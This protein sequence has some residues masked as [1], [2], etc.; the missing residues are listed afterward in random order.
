MNA[1]PDMLNF[2]VGPVMSDDDILAIGAEQVP[3]FRTAEFSEVMKENEKMLLEL[4][5][6]PADSRAVFLTTSGTGAMEAA[7][8]NTL[9]TTDKVL[10][11]NGG[12]FGQRFCDLCSLH[13]IEHTAI[14]LKFGTPLRHEDLEPYENAGYTAFLVNMNETSSGVLYDIELISQFCKRNNL[15]LIVDAVSAFLTDPFSL[16]ASGAGIMLT[17]SQKALGCPPG[18]SM[19]VLTPDAL[20]RVKRI[21]SGSMYLDIK[22]ALTNGERG[23]T[24]FTPAVSILLQ[25]H[26][27]L[28]KIIE[29]GGQKSETDR[30]RS[31]AEDLRT[32]IAHLPLTLFG[33]SPSHGVTAFQTPF[34]VSAHKIFEIL[35]DEYNI[36][37]CP[38]G[39]QY[40]DTVFRIGHMGAL[41]TDDNKRLVEALD[42]LHQRGLL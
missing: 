37:I 8:I 32:R 20:E 2:A 34:G 18:I 33:S 40:K 10:V 5:D 38:N 41:T 7:V 13:S 30:V 42:D 6:A 25:I 17:G 14:E 31:I 15:F 19:L 29:A 27:R 11:V 35:K 24:P 12:S 9:D 3:Y 4:A 28:K 23:Q 26:R 1:M 21:E 16:S 39:G 22:S 36:W